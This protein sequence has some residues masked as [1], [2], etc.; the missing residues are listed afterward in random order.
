MNATTSEAK[1]GK[2]MN[3]K[4]AAP[5]AEPSAVSTEDQELETLACFAWQAMLVDPAVSVALFRELCARVPRKSD[6]WNALGLALSKT[7]KIGEAIAAFEKG[8]A[9][10]PKNIEVWCVLAELSMEQLD[11]PRA[12]SALKQCLELD[13]NARHPSGLRARA[14]IKKGEKLLKQATGG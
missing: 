9:L 5:K 12:A 8:L 7:K 3:A 13:P 2:S 1:N 10:N 14:L 6:Y 11:W 4:A